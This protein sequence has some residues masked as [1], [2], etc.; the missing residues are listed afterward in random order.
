MPTDEIQNFTKD[1]DTDRACQ[2]EMFFDKAKFKDRL[3]RNCK[4]KSNCTV[5]NYFEDYYN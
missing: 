1:I 4:N 5:S 2:D 3:V